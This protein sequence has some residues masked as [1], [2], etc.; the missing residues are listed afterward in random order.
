MAQ[1]FAARLSPR[2]LTLLATLTAAI[3]CQGDG[4]NGPTP[5]PPP[6]TISKV[7]ADPIDIVA[8]IEFGDSLRVEVLASGGTPRA[9]V[10]VTFA[11]SEGS[12]SIA[13]TSVVTNAQGRAAARF[14]TGTRVGTNTA[15]ATLATGGSVSFT[16]VTIP[17]PA[18]QIAFRQRI[19]TADINTSFTPDL[20]ATDA[21]GNA[22]P[23]SRLALFAKTPTIASPGANGAVTVIRTGQTFIVASSTGGGPPDSVLVVAVAP[24]GALISG[25]LARFDLRTDST[26]TVALSIDLRTGPDKLGAAT[27]R[28]RWDPTLLEFVSHAEGSPNVGAFVN[29]TNAGNGI[30]TLAVANAA[31]L[32]GKTELVRL[33]LKTRSTVGKSGALAISALEVFSAGSFTDLLPRT[34]AVSHPLVLR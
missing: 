7:G 13:P 17:G 5:P 19:V 25:D 33:T 2:W 31:G 21:N 12:G 23:P 1:V 16:T 3:A 11:V 8:G 30:L 27:V 10:T 24:N 32:A 29:T 14:T 22:V 6:P 15:T 28:V 9:G 18:T 26:F 4:G 20:T 34:T